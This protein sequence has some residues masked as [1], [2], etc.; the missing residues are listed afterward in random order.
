[1]NVVTTID[2]YNQHA[3][4]YAAQ[5]LLADVADRYTDF[6]DCLNPGARILG[7]GC[8]SG[9]DTKHFVDQGFDVLPAPVKQLSP[10]FRVRPVPHSRCSLCIRML[11]ET[12]RTSKNIEIIARHIWLRCPGVLDWVFLPTIFVYPRSSF[13]YHSSSL[14]PVRT[15]SSPTT[16]GRLTSIP[17]VASSAYCSSSVISGSFLESPVSR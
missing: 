4:E 14:N 5:T 7:L 6:E 11:A 1:M 16:I 15:K 2:Y 17:S 10:A 12:N 3:A 9:R 8:G 13:A